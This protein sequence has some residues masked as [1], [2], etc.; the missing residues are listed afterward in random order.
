MKPSCRPAV[1]LCA[2]GFALSFCGAARAGAGTAAAEFL[3]VDPSAR[4]VSLGGAVTA[5]GDGAFSFFHNPAGLAQVNRQEIALSHVSW[6]EG[7]ASEYAVYALP[8]GEN[9]AAAVGGSYFS[10]GDMDELDIAGNALGSYSYTG[11]SGGLSLAY[12]TGGFA[13][14]VTGKMVRISMASRSADGLAG[15]IGALYNAGMLTFGAS[16]RNYG[17]GMKL[18]TET[19]AQPGTL[20]IGASLRPAKYLLLAAEA[21]RPRDSNENSYSAGGELSIPGETNE[22]YICLRGGWRFNQEANTGSGLNLGV[23]VKFARNFTLDYAYS[24]MGEFGSSQ[25]ISLRLDFGALRPGAPGEPEKPGK[26]LPVPDYKG[27]N[28]KLTTVEQAVADYR[29]GKISMDE[30]REKM[31]QN[32]Q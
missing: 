31:R 22:D 15:D 24:P 21:G 2:C 19:A 9:A 12:K 18:Y 5:D 29:A 3:E 27:G 20:N 16:L 28:R 23:G 6:L 4:S 10:S 14:G 8:L 11:L 25:R 32:Y 26:R 17:G 30:L 1:W 7:I 13:A